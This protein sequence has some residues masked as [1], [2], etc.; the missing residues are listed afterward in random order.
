MKIMFVIR[1]HSFVD[2]ITNS[3]SELFVI[4]NRKSEGAVRD[5]IESLI[6]LH[7]G[8]EDDTSERE[9]NKRRTTFEE[10]FS[11]TIKRIETEEE[12]QNEA[13]QIYSWIGGD[14][15]RIVDEA[16]KAV[17]EKPKKTWWKRRE[18]AERKA[19]DDAIKSG[20][21]DYKKYIK[22]G[23]ILVSSASDNSIPWGIVEAVEGLFD[24]TRY[25]LG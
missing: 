8:D 11:D 16:A 12:A 13:F 4:R 24:C 3:S 1:P 25:H 5:A 22:V 7:N 15:E 6:K 2:V 17:P 20:A 14:I 21:F 19:F 9:Y 23:D 10:A 18:K